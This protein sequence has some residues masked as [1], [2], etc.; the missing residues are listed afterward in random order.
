MFS[1]LH[2]DQNFFYK[3]ILSDISKAREFQ[4]YSAKNVEKAFEILNKYHIDIIITNL[5]YEDCGEELIKQILDSKHQSTPVVVLTATENPALKT[6]LLELGV[7]EYLNKDRFLDYLNAYLNRLQNIDAL[8]HQLKNIRIAVLDDNQTQLANIQSY[9]ENNQIDQADFYIHP[10]A[11][12]ASQ[13][14]YHIY[15][16]DLI[17]PDI[18][19]EEVIAAIRGR[20]KYAVIIALSSIDSTTLITDVLALG[21]MTILKSLFLNVF[22]WLDLRPVLEPIALWKS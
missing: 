15:I 20:D 16:I 5:G 7:T 19:G 13:K 17:T 12:I 3:E 2:I 6:R 1:L 4:Y 8:S 14:F 18:S 11:L 9:L 21:L 10:A 22:L